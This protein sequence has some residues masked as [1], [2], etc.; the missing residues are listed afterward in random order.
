M[1][2]GV[3]VEVSHESRAYA[4]PSRAPTRFAFSLDRHSSAP[5]VGSYAWTLRPGFANLLAR[6]TPSVAR[7]LPTSTALLSRLVAMAVPPIVSAAVHVAELQPA[8]GSDT[9][10]SVRTLPFV[11]WTS[12][13]TVPLSI[14]MSGASTVVAPA[15]AL[16][17]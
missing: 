12:S 16:G 5:V 14:R 11:S 7:K 13:H 8:A 9:S 17:V 4:R 1:T 15:T 3:Q 10:R 2:P 6:T